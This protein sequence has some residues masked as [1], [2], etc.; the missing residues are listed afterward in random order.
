MNAVGVVPI[1]EMP[2]DEDDQADSDVEATETS[3]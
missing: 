3:L 1:M 2:L